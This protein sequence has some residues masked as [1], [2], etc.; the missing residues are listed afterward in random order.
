MLEWE[1]Q[2][3]ITKTDYTLAQAY[4]ED[5]VKATDTYNQNAGSKPQQYESANQLADLGD[6]IRGY[7]QRIASSN[8]E[9]AANTQTKE[10]LAALEAQISK[11]TETMMALAVLMN[12]E[13]QQPNANNNTNN[14]SGKERSRMH[15]DQAKPRNMR[16]Y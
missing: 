5:L 3:E 7:I 10:K 12:K 11:L 4:F 16:G 6:E 15:Q 1:K 2:P 14:N 13:N 9:S 8:A